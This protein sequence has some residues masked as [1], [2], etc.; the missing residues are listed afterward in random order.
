[1]A[2]Q[3]IYGLGLDGGK[4]DFKFFNGT[5]Y[6][7]F[8]TALAPLS[9]TDWKRATQEGT[10]LPP[11]GYISVN[12]SHYA[13]GEQ[14]RR[15]QVKEAPKSAQ[16]YN[17]EYYGVLACASF[18]GAFE[19]SAKIDV[20]ATHAPNDNEYT[21]DIENS[22]KGAW[23][24]VSWRGE[25]NFFVE[26]VET[27]DEPLGG[28]FHHSLTPQYKSRKNNPFPSM[29]FLVL[30]IGS[31][32]V[33]TAIFD[34]G[35]ILDQSSIGSTR[36]GMRTVLTQFESDLR[37]NNRALFKDSEDLDPI[38]VEE[39]FQTGAYIVGKNVIHCSD[40]A[41]QYK[42]ILLNDCIDIMRSKAGGFM[43]IDAVAVTGGGG[44]LMLPL[45]QKELP[46]VDFIPVEPDN[47]KIRYANAM[48]AYKFFKMMELSNG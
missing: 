18:V 14:A 47:S 29:V 31:G 12:G 2:K 17:R 25:L 44:G 7:H 16:R 28:V 43:N 41:T 34:R 8:R 27:I 21:S 36:I 22:L 32:T 13:I 3:K 48:G 9:V 20:Y 19:H 11:V 37:T 30:D 42:Q 40:I 23:N 4:G 33:D 45:L 24:V 10:K 35:Y 15:Y 46:R 5:Y 26:K 6:S 1:M 39:A 38:R